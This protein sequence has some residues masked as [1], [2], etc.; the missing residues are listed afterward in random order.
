MCLGLNSQNKRWRASR[1]CDLFM[2]A[3]KENVLL[4]THDRGFISD[5]QLLR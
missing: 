1:R 4:K 3:S 5:K 2:N